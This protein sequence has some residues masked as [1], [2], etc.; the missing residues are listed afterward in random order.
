M[1][2]LSVT[3]TTETKVGET[4]SMVFPDGV[5]TVVLTPFTSSDTVD[6]TSLSKTLDMQYESDVNGLVLLGTTSEAPTL[7]HD[8]KLEIV[9]FVH[10]YNEGVTPSKRKFIVVGTGGNVTKHVVSFS[11]EVEAYCDALMVTVPNYNKPQQ[12]GVVDLFQQVSKAVP[13]RP[14][15]MYNIP[16]RTSLDMTPESMA[17]VLNTC[18]NVVALKEASGNYENVSRLVDLVN[19]KTDRDL[20]STFK[21][22]SGDD[23]N[24]VRLCKDYQGRGVISVASNAVPHQISRLITACNAGKFDEATKL[25][26]KYSEF[27]KYLFVESNPVPVKN[28]LHQAGV[29]ESD[30]VRRPLMELDDTDKVHRLYELYNSVMED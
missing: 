26:S 30:R 17:T 3:E 22:F 1:E 16:G 10:A 9:K 21:L 18:P 24:C 23:V 2:R 4:S 19:T 25:L 20:K 7:E 12:R 29:F 8:E 5:Y 15:M 11:K 6:F 14:I 13:T 27:L 28:V